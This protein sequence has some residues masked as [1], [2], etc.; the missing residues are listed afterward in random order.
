MAANLE[1]EISLQSSP[2]ICSLYLETVI[3]QQSNGKTSLYPHL[4]P[5][6]FLGLRV[7][8]IKVRFQPFKNVSLVLC[9]V[10]LLNVKRF[11]VGMN[12]GAEF[13]VKI[14]GLCKAW[15][16]LVVWLVGIDFS[17][18]VQSSNFLVLCLE[19]SCSSWLHLVSNDISPK[20]LKS[21]WSNSLRLRDGGVTEGVEPSN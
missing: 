17:E 5:L 12:V 9:E 1:I 15:P 14:V 8:S 13:V 11:V 2:S 6:H 10:D 21:D 7:N 16:C 19:L 20:K 3:L 4:P 18:N